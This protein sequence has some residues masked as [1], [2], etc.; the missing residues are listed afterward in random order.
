MKA[1]FKF[2]RVYG[3]GKYSRCEE[4]VCNSKIQDGCMS[5]FINKFFANFGAT[6]VRAIEVKES[7]IYGKYHTFGKIE[8]LSANF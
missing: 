2:Y 4:F 1:A 8:K 6:Y 3:I 7:Q 5:D